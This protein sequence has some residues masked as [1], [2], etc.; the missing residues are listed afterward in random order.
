ML[1]NQADVITASIGETDGFSDNPWA[2]V[3]SR[4]VEKGI[5]VTISA[6]NEGDSGAFYS[7]S[8]S[9][10]RGVLSVAA[11]NATAQPRINKSNLK[12]QPRPGY[13][14]TWGPTNELLI[15]P[16]I[17]APGWDIVSTV[18]NQSYGELSGTSMS[19]PYI[20]GVAALYIGE[21]GGREMFGPG[22]AKM[23][24]DRIASSGRSL[25][26]TTYETLRN[27]TAPPFQVGTGLVDAWKVLKYDT[28]LGYEP[29]ALMDKQFF[30]PQWRI[31]I[32]NNGDVTQ[33]YNFKLEP[34]AGVNIL[35]N[36]FGIEILY[37]MKPVTIVPNVTLPE[38]VM[39]PAGE[40]REVE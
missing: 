27:Y 12:N 40:T 39:V 11:V 30:K 20:A 16:D 21:Y 7:S 17:G 28:D 29:F 38:P 3:S 14:T 1:T 24:R 19:A 32:T 4:L 25:P 35:D 22:F 8:G 9:N 23:L 34:G 33:R 26:W 6:G 31:N 15:K 2:L 10:G 37:D 18:L 13:F 5:V 36:F